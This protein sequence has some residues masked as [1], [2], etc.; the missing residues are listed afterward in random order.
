MYVYVYVYM[1]IYIYIYIHVQTMNF[2]W[3]FLFVVLVVQHAR[4]DAR[5]FRSPGAFRH[6]EIR[7]WR[8]GLAIIPDDW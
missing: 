8:F 1:Y 5:S 4:E 2:L 6:L 3:S 7:P